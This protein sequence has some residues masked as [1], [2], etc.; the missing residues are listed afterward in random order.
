MA[1][2]LSKQPF[3]S[4]HDTQ[5]ER[6]YVNNFLVSFQYVIRIKKKYS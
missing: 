1:S 3:Y 6:V 4:D 5:K 2:F